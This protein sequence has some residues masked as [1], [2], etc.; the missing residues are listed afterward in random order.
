MYLYLRLLVEIETRGENA[1]IEQTFVVIVSTIQQMISF[2][3]HRN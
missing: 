2:L 1:L 3:R